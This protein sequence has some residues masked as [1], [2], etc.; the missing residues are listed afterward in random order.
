MK[1]IAAIATPLA[2][3]GISVIRLSGEKAIS[4][5]E[6]IFQPVSGKKL[7]QMEGYTCLLYTSQYQGL[8]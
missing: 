2:V 3:G 1:T 8:F 4:L 6:Q 5:A 7:S